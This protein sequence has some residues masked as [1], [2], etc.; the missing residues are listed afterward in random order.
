M[1]AI[2]HV[3]CIEKGWGNHPEVATAGKKQTLRQKSGYRSRDHRATLMRCRSVVRPSRSHRSP[4]PSSFPGVP[5]NDHAEIRLCRCCPV[6]AMICI[7][8]VTPGFPLA[9][10]EGPA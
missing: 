8:R 9:T 10:A 6:R 3:F 1:S 2:S 5:S 4:P 7:S